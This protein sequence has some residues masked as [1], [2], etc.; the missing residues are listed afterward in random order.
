MAIRRVRLSNVERHVRVAI[1]R[2][3]GHSADAVISVARDNERP[4][5]VIV[6]I[7][8]G[9]NA[10]AAT[11]ELRQHGYDVEPTDYEPFA[12]GNYG[13]QLRVRP[14]PASST[15]NAW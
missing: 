4:E 6:H 13:V 1:A 12:P 3:I 9:G 2:R 8:S 7:N 14:Q 5:T 11:V 15:A 10:A